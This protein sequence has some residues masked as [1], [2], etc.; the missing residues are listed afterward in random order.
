[1]VY[2]PLRKVDYEIAA[3]NGISKE[4]AYRRYE[5]RHWSKQ[6]AI[7]LPLGTRRNEVLSKEDYE[8]AKENGISPQT[9]YHRRKVLKW[10][11][12]KCI[13]E[14]IPEKV[15][16]S[17]WE[18]LATKAGIGYAAFRK[19]IKKGMA[20]EQAATTPNKKKNINLQCG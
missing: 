4:A 10:P 17:D 20:P 8:I 16:W 15:K 19:R 18:E 11:I 7:T 12:E 2:E 3:K 13:T 9:A 5:F 6:D 1:M 14:P